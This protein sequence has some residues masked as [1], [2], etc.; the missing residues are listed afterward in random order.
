MKH[1]TRTRSRISNRKTQ[2]GMTLIE[3]AISLAIAAALIFGIFYMVGVV[4][5][6][7]IT[8]NESQYLN[9]MAADLRTKFSAQASYAGLNA[10]NLIS[11][12]IAPRPMVVGTALRSGFSTAVTIAPANVNGV[13]D[14]GFQFTYLVPS[15]NCADFVTAT[16]GAF[17]RVSIAGTVVK[18]VTTGDNQ[19]SVTD[20]ANCN[21]SATSN[22]N[23]TLLFAQGR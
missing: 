17:S 22:S 15:D 12:N 11:M 16:E 14:D 7:R 6:K 21:A 13:A 9:M 1:N 20:L 3:M 18:N 2:K 4:Q 5:N 23:V 8:T 19:I 10:A